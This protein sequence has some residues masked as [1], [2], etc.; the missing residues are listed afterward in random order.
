MNLDGTNRETLVSGLTLP[1]DVALDVP[2]G[3]MYFTEEGS[4]MISR[5]NLDGTGLEILLTGLSA[6]EAI[7]VVIVKTPEENVQDLID[8]ITDLINTGDIPNGQGT[9]LLATL[10]NILNSIQPGN[11]NAINLLHTFINKVETFIASGKI[12]QEIGQPLIDAA[13]T[14]IAQLSN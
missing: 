14:V 1:I 12:T 13:Q 8:I 5:A 6:P 10:N 11:P 4:G 2:S 9:S 7:E 3:K